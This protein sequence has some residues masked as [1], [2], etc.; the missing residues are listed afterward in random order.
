MALQLQGFSDIRLSL[1]ASHS[2]LYFFVSLALCCYCNDMTIIFFTKDFN[3]Q[4]I[5]PKRIFST[6]ISEDMQFFKYTIIINIQLFKNK[7]NSVKYKSLKVILLSHQCHVIP[8]QLFL[9]SDFLFDG[10]RLA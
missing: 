9:K 2:Y 7:N 3:R 5:S 4:F 6:T 8:F 10:R 1:R